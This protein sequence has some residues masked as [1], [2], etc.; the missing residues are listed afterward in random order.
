MPIVHKAVWSIRSLIRSGLHAVSTLQRKIPSFVVEVQQLLRAVYLSSS[1][2]GGNF[3]IY[4]D[5][6][7]SLMIMIMMGRWRFKQPCVY[8]PFG[9]IGALR[10]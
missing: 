4:W 3:L 10:K 2:P 5:V 8:W 7:H 1:A 9:Q 6:V